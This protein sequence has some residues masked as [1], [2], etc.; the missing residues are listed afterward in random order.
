[1]ESGDAM[2]NEEYWRFFPARVSNVLSTVYEPES[3]EIT[4]ATRAAYYLYVEDRVPPN[5]WTREQFF[6]SAGRRGWSE[7]EIQRRWRSFWRLVDQLKEESSAPVLLHNPQ[8]VGTIRLETGSSAWTFSLAFHR[9]TL[10]DIDMVVQWIRQDGWAVT[11]PTLVDGQEDC[12]SVSVKKARPHM[13]VSREDL[14]NVLVSDGKI[15]QCSPPSESAEPPV[16][17]KP[18]KPFIDIAAIQSVLVNIVEEWGRHRNWIELY[19]MAFPSSQVPPLSALTRI[20][21]LLTMEEARS[22]FHT[23]VK[24]LD[25][26]MSQLKDV[27]HSDEPSIDWE[28][29]RLLSQRNA[30]LGPAWQQL[31]QQLMQGIAS[32]IN[33]AETSSV[34]PSEGELPRAKAIWTREVEMRFRDLTLTGEIEEERAYLQ[35]EM[36]GM[37]GWVEWQA[38]RQLVR[39]GDPSG[40]ESILLEE[41]ALWLKDDM[42]TVVDAIQLSEQHTR[43]D[44]VLILRELLPFQVSQEIHLAAARSYVFMNQESQALLEFEAVDRDV[45]VGETAASYSVALTRLARYEEAVPW[46]LCALKSQGLGLPLVDTIDNLLL[47]GGISTKDVLAI[48]EGVTVQVRSLRLAR[49]LESAYTSRLECLLDSPGADGDAIV[50]AVGEWTQILIADGASK[51]AWEQYLFYRPKLK[52][53]WRL[54]ILDGMAMDV[55][56]ALPEVEAIGWEY[57]TVATDAKRILE[58]Y[59]FFSELLEPSESVAPRGDE[60]KPCSLVLVGANKGIRAQVKNR[61]VNDYGFI[62]SDIA[63]VESPWEGHVSTNQI[64]S[65]V[66]TH[67]VVVAFTAMMKHSLWYQLDVPASKVVFPPSGGI[68]GALASILERCRVPQDVL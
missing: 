62:S 40:L 64:R 23:F 27:S 49:S 20:Y 48:S 11:E 54:K 16:V 68:S 17:P 59:Q 30:L 32:R 12:V 24:A 63:E 31:A 9:Y 2:T 52:P 28:P 38:C 10:H 36:A 21:Q 8:G 15:A 61:L 13:D 47:G 57:S 29:Y 3:S 37:A 66:K 60:V 19:R 26:K 50:G 65:L 56:N 55:S 1:M 6:R 4:E 18:L 58:T 41:M 34:A 44:L 35:T 33:V 45:I 51:T 22:G 5:R 53:S 39:V 14:M 43:P 42:E 7:A 25:T 46:V 67:Q